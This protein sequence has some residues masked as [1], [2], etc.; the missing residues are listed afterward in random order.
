M[1]RADRVAAADGA[2]VV[3]ITGAG[4]YVGACAVAGFGAAG[5]HV[6]RLVRHPGEGRDD[7]AYALDRPVMDDALDGVDTLVHC[8]Y[9]FS[10]L[11]RGQI[12]FVNVLGTQRLL[13]AARA[14]GVRRTIFISS[15]SAYR[16]TRQLYGRAKLAGE[17][18]ALSQGMCAVRLGLVYGDDPGGMMGTLRR[19]AALPVI[20]LVGGDSRQFT[21]HEEDLA[22]GLLALARVERCPDEVV[23]LAHPQPVAFR[24]LMA[25]IRADVG[26]GPARVIPVPWR[27]VYWGMRV[28][29]R[30]P[31]RLPLRADSLLGLVRPAASV[32]R[33]AC[34]E[35]L[36]VRVRPFSA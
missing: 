1:P 9:D 28:A 3:A 23:G 29:E 17:A 26:A 2:R 35:E 25:R 8:A 21:L 6:R 7:V 12:W 4:G 5:Y 30:G 22:A 18:M 10:V 36:G 33:P 34:I 24:D 32:P 19:L 13:A 31:A 16:G 20:P 14:A 15:M 11:R 27:P